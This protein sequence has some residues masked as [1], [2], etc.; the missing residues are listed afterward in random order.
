M[1]G[2]LN[3]LSA[4]WSTCNALTR[5][6]TSYREIARRLNCHHSTCNHQI[7]WP[8]PWNQ[9]VRDH[10]R[11]GRPRATNIR[12]YRHVTLTHTR[13]M[14][15]QSCNNYSQNKTYWLHSSV[16]QNYLTAFEG[17]K[18]D[19]TTSL[20]WPIL[21]PRRRQLRMNWARTHAR[22]SLCVKDVIDGKDPAWWYGV[23]FRR[24]YWTPLVFIGGSLT[25][26]RSMDTILQ[27]IVLL[28]LEQHDDVTTFQV[29]IT[30]DLTVLTL[31]W[32]LLII[33]MYM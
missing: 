16:C 18:D 15:R 28:F 8:V 9:S 13:D 6:V 26:Q 24:T 12:Q 11:S 32:T 5:N 27:P 14:I 10:L 20:L 23:I 19:V 17:S 30:R 21:T 7:R 4:L 2:R 31:P 3:D 29:V 33:L 25:A 22:W 1:M